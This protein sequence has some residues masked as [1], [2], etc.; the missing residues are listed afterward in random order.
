M[1]LADTRSRYGWISIIN[2]W[3]IAALIL[4]LIAFGL[5]LEGLPRSPMKGDLIQVHKLL[6]VLALT[7]ALLRLGWR[8]LQRSP[9]AVEGQPALAETLRTAL[10]ATLLV[11]TVLLPLSGIVMSLYNNHPVSLLGLYTIPAQ[12]EVGWLA[13]TGHI[14][15]EWGS[16]LVL[17]LVAGHALV[18]LKHHFIDRDDTLSRMLPDRTA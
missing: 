2:H 3:A 18:S 11:A 16:Y 6:G 1:A 15:H 17:L 7:L 12:G 13:A 5:I 8:A 4:G 9:G 14:V 10:H